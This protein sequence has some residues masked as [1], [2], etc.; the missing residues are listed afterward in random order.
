MVYGCI[1]E[2]VAK[3]RGVWGGGKVQENVNAE[4]V[5]NHRYF[6]FCKSLTSRLM[7]V[8]IIIKV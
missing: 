8:V 6:C 3:L 4:M 1:V 5:V 2:M 7:T